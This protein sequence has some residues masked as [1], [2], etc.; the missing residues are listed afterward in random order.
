LLHL[1]QPTC[2]IEASFRFR[3]KIMISST[4]ASMADSSWLTSPTSFFWISISITKSCVDC[5]LQLGF[6]EARIPLSEAV[7]LLANAP[8]SNSA[9]MAIDEALEDVEKGSFGDIPLHLKDSHYKGSEKLGHGLSYKYSHLY[10]GNY[11][12]QQYLPDKIK[13]KKYYIPGKN[14]NEQASVLYWKEIKK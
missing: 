11:V 12:K 6:P 5:A 1:T 14:K 9:I 13:D 8:K 4:R 3:K 10:P 2:G 7:L